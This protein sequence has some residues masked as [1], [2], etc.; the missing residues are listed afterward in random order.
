MSIGIILTLIATITNMIVA[1]TI[2][3]FVYKKMDAKDE[4]E[5]RAIRK[6]WE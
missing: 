2:L 6:E 5:Y 4:A 1:S 3:H